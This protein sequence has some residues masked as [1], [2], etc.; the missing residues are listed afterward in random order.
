M[1]TVSDR[2]CSAPPE[3]DLPQ[4]MSVAGDAQR[5][6]FSRSPDRGVA[7]PVGRPGE[8]DL[9]PHAPENGSGV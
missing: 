5:A 8:T 6:W 9:Y 2:H 7:N 3:P 4:L 1:Y